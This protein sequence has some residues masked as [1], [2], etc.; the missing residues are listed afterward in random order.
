MLD[1]ASSVTRN[2]M[3]TQERFPRLE[4][5]KNPAFFQTVTKIWAHE[6]LSGSST[7]AKPSQ[8]QCRG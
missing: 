8:V 7:R 6:C 2:E 3:W 1:P 5:G 4:H